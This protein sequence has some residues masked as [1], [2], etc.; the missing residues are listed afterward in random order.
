MWKSALIPFQIMGDLGE[1]VQLL[2]LPE[3]GKIAFGSIKALQ[4]QSILKQLCYSVYR[5]TL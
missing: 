2:Y 1:T 4:H 5:L 3:L